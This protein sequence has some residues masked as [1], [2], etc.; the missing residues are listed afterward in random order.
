MAK[1]EKKTLEQRQKE[2]HAE[3]I[4]SQ[5]LSLRLEGALMI[6]NELIEEKK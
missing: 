4:K 3:L 6:V 2:L 5:E 1:K